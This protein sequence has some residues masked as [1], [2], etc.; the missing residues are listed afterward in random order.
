MES[1]RFAVT[2]A[3]DARDKTLENVGTEQQRASDHAPLVADVVGARKPCYVRQ[4]AR[5][6]GQY[7]GR[8]ESDQP[9]ERRDSDRNE[10]RPVLDG[11]GQRRGGE[12]GHDSALSLVRT[13]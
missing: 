6:E 10:Q 3:T 9:D 7:A 13:G 11:M 1:M 2:G 8:Q 12:R 4:V 5:D